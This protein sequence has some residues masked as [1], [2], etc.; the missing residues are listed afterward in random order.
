MAVAA[1]TRFAGENVA[2][3]DRLDGVSRVTVRAYWHLACGFLLQQARVHGQFGDFLVV[4]AAPANARVTELEELFAPELSLL[5][6]LAGQ[7]LV[8]AIRAGQERVN[9]GLE[10]LGIY[11][12]LDPAALGKLDLGALVRVAR[13]ARCGLGRQRG[14]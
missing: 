12:G 1:A 9:R 8:V 14:A 10:P 6:P 2:S 3:G 7:R 13:Q 4:M 11:S 5:V